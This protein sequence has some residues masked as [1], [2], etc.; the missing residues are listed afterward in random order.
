MPA[1]SKE[2]RAQERRER[3]A[4]KAAHQPESKVSALLGGLAD[5]RSAVEKDQRSKRRRSG[6]RRPA[7]VVQ[8]DALQSAMRNY[9]SRFGPAVQ[10]HHDVIAAFD[11]PSRSPGGGRGSGVSDPTFA[12]VEGDTFDDRGE[13][14]EQ[15]VDMENV[16]RNLA[17]SWSMVQAYIEKWTS[18]PSTLEIPKCANECGRE[19]ATYPTASG[20]IRPRGDGLCDACRM[21]KSRAERE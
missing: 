13:L 21:A 1:K 19:A 14:L 11:G 3:L 5:R 2:E 10:R 17:E 15:M 9:S 12:A 20:D 18:A 6:G 4:R 7:A 8:F 16:V